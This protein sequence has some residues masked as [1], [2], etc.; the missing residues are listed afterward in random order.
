MSK[1][2]LTPEQ[3]MKAKWGN[4]WGCQTP[5]TLSPEKRNATFCIGSWAG[6]GPVWMDA[7]NLTATG[8]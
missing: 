7:K 8:I 5:A 6:P 4:R 1:V 3:A 2:Q